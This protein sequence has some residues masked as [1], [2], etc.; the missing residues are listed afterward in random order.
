MTRSILRV[1]IVISAIISVIGCAK[2]ALPTGGPKDVLPPVMVKSVPPNGA[3]NFKGENIVLTF[4]E[5][6]TLDKIN[7]KFMVS[8]PMRL[9]PLITVRGKNILIDFKE[10]TKD[11]TTYTLYFQD[12]IRDLDESNPLNNFQFVFSTGKVIDSL[13]VTGNVLNAFN[14][15]PEKS[16]LV[17]MYSNLNDS[18]P[19]KILPDYISQADINGYFR[20]NNVKTGNYK[21]YALQDNNNNKKYDPADEAFAFIDSV[22]NVNSARNYLPPLKVMPDTLKTKGKARGIKLLRKTVSD[23]TLTGRKE[24]ELVPYIEGEHKLYMFTRLKNVHYLTSNARKI[25]YQFIYTLSLPPDTSKFEFSIPGSGEKDYF[26][27][28]N[29]TQDTIT[30]WLRDS[31]LY[32]RPEI[33][34][35]IRYPYTDTT[36]AIV[37]KRDTVKMRFVA[38]R[39]PRG[40]AVKKSYRYYTNV[41]NGYLKPGQQIILSSQTPFRQPDTSRIK[42]FE[43]TTTTSIRIPYSIRKDSLNSRKFFF[44]AKFKE[45]GKYI[46]VTDSGAFGDIYRERSDSTGISFFVRETN[47]FGRL[48]MNI[49]KSEGDLIFQLLDTKENIIDEKKLK[50]N[51]AVVF[52]LI[53]KG[54]YKVRVIY[55]LNGDGKW[56]T[57]DYD[58]KQQPEPVSY[59][60][61]EIDVKIDWEIQQDWDV[62]RKNFKKR[63]TETKSEKKS[64]QAG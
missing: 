52:P 26:I 30:V 7:E 48:T 45:G 54:K 17:L 4:D 34:T 22:I 31:S 53:E 27:E 5:Y 19:K 18:A 56:T 59:Y 40:R 41:Q 21:I 9:K 51:G 23:T 20:I 32:T 12:A 1:W 43:K 25:P 36:G 61:D 57:G 55:D 60:S 29:L 6:F 33:T 63:V 24:K 28:K 10:K 11:S 13:S 8:P 15:E 2:Q 64:P 37:Y 38:V 47:A 46:L 49:T 39:A 42:L 58:K 62:G 35:L 3:T 50:N 16:T 14:L 44:N